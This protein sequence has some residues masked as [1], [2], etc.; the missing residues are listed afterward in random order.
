MLK[1]Y[2]TVSGMKFRNRTVTDL[3][4]LLCGN[5]KQWFKY[6]TQRQLAELMDDAGIQFAGTESSRAKDLASSLRAVLDSF[7]GEPPPSF[8]RL[9]ELVM[10]RE[11]ATED[12]ASDRRGALDALNAILKREQHIAFYDE[13]GRCR[14]RQNATGSPRPSSEPPQ[15]ALTPTQVLQ[16]D[17][18]AA[19]LD[20]ASEDDIIEHVVI[21]TFR[22]LGFK[23]ITAAGHRD[24]A[25]EYGKDIW[26]KFVLPTKHVIYFGAQVKRE[27]L[28]SAGK[29][30]TGTAN[31][32]EVVQ[33]VRMMLGHE[34]FDPDINSKRLVDHAYIVSGGEITKAAR[35]WIAGELDRSQRSQLLFLDRADI[36][37]LFITNGLQIP[38][39]MHKQP[40]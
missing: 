24:K 5:G 34:V 15:T 36:L 23:R 28:D 6:Y 29:T 40:D 21:P 14:L 12:D 9:I 11:D 22:H 10:D 17:L 32:A 38:K 39:R 27:K 35:N 16:R 25:L 33:Q 8:H 31:V 18:L 13:M 30:R 4:E 26:M 1:H 2:V 37:D 19:Y 7:D 20:A 3:S